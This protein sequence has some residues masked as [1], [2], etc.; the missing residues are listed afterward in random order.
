[1]AA[2]VDSPITH[3]LE[4]LSSPSGLPTTIYPLTT[5]PVD[6][7]VQ[8]ALATK[9]A[10]S[11]PILQDQAV[12][13]LQSALDAIV[14]SPSPTDSIA[15]RHQAN[16]A[17]TD[18]S[19]SA[20]V[21]ALQEFLTGGTEDAAIS[22]ES[23]VTALDALSHYKRAFPSTIAT[24]NLKRDSRLKTITEKLTPVPSPESAEEVE[25]VPDSSPLL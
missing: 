25:T 4:P 7:Y 23:V 24:S 21:R 10:A 19:P 13:G 2:H 9:R 5:S 17:L 1:M 18:G 8:A 3:R 16:Y 6:E 11:K 15:A 22:Q 12:A 20:M 14:K